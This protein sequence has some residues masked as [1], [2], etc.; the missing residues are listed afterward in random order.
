MEAKKKHNKKKTTNK[1]KRAV[2]VPRKVHAVG[3]VLTNYRSQ[4]AENENTYSYF[5][6][7]FNCFHFLIIV[8]SFFRNLANNSILALKQNT[9][10]N[11]SRLFNL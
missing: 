1:K 11:F 7:P 8:L 6:S 9:F 10:V 4:R 3:V 5:I 2:I